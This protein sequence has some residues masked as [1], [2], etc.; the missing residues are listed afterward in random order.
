MIAQPPQLPWTADEALAQITMSLNGLMHVPD[1]DQSVFDNT[2]AF[3]RV[4]LEYVR[5]VDSNSA[6]W[7][8]AFEQIREQHKLTD[9]L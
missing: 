9:H 8:L 7:K 4:V 6:I 1:I 3:V 2:L 5:V